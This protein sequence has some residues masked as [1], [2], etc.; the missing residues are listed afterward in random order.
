MGSMPPL[1]TFL[2]MVVSRWIHGQQL[3]VIEYLSRESLSVTTGDWGTGCFDVSRSAMPGAS[4]GGHVLAGALGNSFFG[5]DIRERREWRW[6][7]GGR[8]LKLHRHHHIF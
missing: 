1:L 4:D 5:Q 3:I 6:G 7:A 2:L 8:E